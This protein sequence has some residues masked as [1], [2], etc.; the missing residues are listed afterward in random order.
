MSALADSTQTKV[1][2]SLIRHEFEP[3]VTNEDG[4]TWDEFKHLF[5]KPLVKKE[6]VRLPCWSPAIF[7]VKYAS[8]D[9]CLFLW[10]LVLDI[11][12]GCDPER[13]INSLKQFSYIIHTSYSHCEGSPRFRVILPLSAP[14]KKAQWDGFWANVTEAIGRGQVDKVCKDK[15]RL[16]FL[17]VVP[18]ER[19]DQYQVWTNDGELFDPTPYLPAQEAKK[20]RTPASSEHK[21]DLERLFS[22]DVEDGNKHLAFTTLT[23]RMRKEDVPLETAELLLEQVIKS[24][25]EDR[26]KEKSHD[27][28]F[29]KYQRDLQKVYDKEE[30]DP[31]FDNGKRINGHVAPSNV[32]RETGEVYE[33]SASSAPYKHK[34]NLTDLGNTERML[35]SFDGDL[36][37]ISAWKR[38]LVW[39]GKRF[40]VDERGEAPVMARAK[41]V[42]R[43]MWRD[44]ADM[45][46]ET[47][48]E[49]LA[50]SE[51]K[52]YIG[53]CESKAKLE[54]MIALAKKDMSVS[55]ATDELDV[56]PWLF[57]VANGTID[58]KSGSI[59]PFSK[60]DLITKMVEIPYD[61]NAIC[62]RWNAFLLSVFGGDKELARFIYRAIGYSLTGDIREHALFFLFGGGSNGKSTL[63]DVL[64]HLMGD[65]SKRLNADSLMLTRFA[66][67]N[68]PTPEIAKLKGARLVAVSETSSTG[69]LDES[70]VKDL[71]GGDRITACMKYGDPFEFDPTHKLWMSGNHKPD[72]ANNDEGIWRRIY[73]IEFKESFTDDAPDD[74][75]RKDRTLPYVLR[76][77]LPGI[78]TWAIKGCLDWQNKG[79]NPPQRVLDAVAEY[80]TSQDVMGDFIT[81][82]TTKGEN[83]FCKTSEMYAA[84]KSWSLDNGLHPVS[85]KKFHPNMESRGYRRSETMGVW[86]FRQIG[87]NEDAKSTSRR[88]E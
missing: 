19:K 34:F 22:G 26:F 11:D 62:D 81:Q 3:V 73:L 84:Y 87:L 68:G 61:A 55:I 51:F 67:Q 6:K 40:L 8:D 4:A 53:K 71:T 70:K 57:N 21:V 38:F 33:Q 7:S 85:S 65:Y 46:D 88:A 49:K 15:R 14:V 5:D 45:P 16:Y 24:F 23:Y 48:V 41:K 31:N 18:P 37:Y 27:K 83:E 79:L 43:G 28:V 30:T 1:R 42:V 60:N 35:A 86:F 72:I 13:F 59:R 39:D 63:M 56:N 75:H 78:L 80:R 25:P 47:P 9:T 17:P 2:F 10:S 32:D 82:C 36:R 52:S 77:E 12:T 44:V 54:S 64:M 20:E 50:V 66:N 74:A 76:S 29:K 69:K 58:L